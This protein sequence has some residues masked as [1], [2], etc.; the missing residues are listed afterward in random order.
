MAHGSK[1]KG[2]LIEEKKLIDRR[3]KRWLQRTKLG[4]RFSR[5]K[6]NA[7][8]PLI[9]ELGDKHEA[10]GE[11]IPFYRV[12]IRNLTPFILV[13][14]LNSLHTLLGLIFPFNPEKHS[15]RINR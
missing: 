3:D 10:Q 13:T 1:S 5:M 14:I 7:E 9:V 15:A 8:K 2:E 4:S 6:Y 11:F 12:Q